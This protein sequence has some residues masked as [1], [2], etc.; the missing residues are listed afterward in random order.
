MNIV[1]LKKEFKEYVSTF[2]FDDI[3]IK[4]KYYHSLRVMNIIKLIS[5]DEKFSKEEQEIS[6]LIGILHD[7]ARFS[8][9]VKYKTYND[10]DSVDHGD[11]A[12]ELLF[13][14]NK[15]EN[16]T[17]N[18]NYYSKI[19]NA[20]KY[21][22]KYLCPSNLS[23]CDKLL[24]KAIRDADKL[25]LLYMFAKDISIFEYCNKDISNGVKKSFYSNSSINK[26]NIKNKND[27][28]LLNLA[29]VFD[30]N[31][32]YSF[33]YLKRNKIIEKMYSRI[34]NIEVFKEYFDYII[35]YIN[36]KV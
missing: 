18:K 10:L 32:S 24:C 35:N 1:K 3:N 21:H 29:M 25:D 28:I 8:Q 6:I 7:Y 22:N 36:E 17:L 27:L 20:I 13:N 30:L 14:E 9:W 2:E 34:R 15:I 12:I 5:I 16:F 23:E 19:Y 4:R 33:K 31:F 11:L 26:K